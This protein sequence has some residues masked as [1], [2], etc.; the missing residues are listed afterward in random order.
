MGEFL[1]LSLIAIITIIFL[2]SSTPN[3]ENILLLGV[4][5]VAAQKLLPLMRQIFAQWSAL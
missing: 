4:F 3:S 2:N 5:A 1:A